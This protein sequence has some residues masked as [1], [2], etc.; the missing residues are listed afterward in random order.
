[1]G[2]IRGEIGGQITGTVGDVTITTW[3]GIKVVRR[4]RGPSRVPPSPAQQ[5]Q[6]QRFLLASEYAKEVGADP[7]RKA[8]YEALAKGQPTTWRA[9]A[10][11]DY[12]TPPLIVRVDVDEYTG[13][14]GQ[15]I[16]I[17]VHDVTCQRVKVH[18]LDPSQGVGANNLGALVEEGEAKRAVEGQ[19]FHW[20]YRTQVNFPEAQSGKPFRLLLEAEDLAGNK[21]T[22]T[23]EGEF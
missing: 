8:L 4:K 6:R 23:V 19:D 14:A 7:E 15:R 17:F 22:H 2:K 3:K 1:M 5:Q 11:Q 20:V 16:D 9:L 18:L 12:L 21:V 10:T 13:Q